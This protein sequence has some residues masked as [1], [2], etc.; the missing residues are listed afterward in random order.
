MSEPTQTKDATQAPKK[1]RG[2]AAGLG[3]SVVVGVLMIE[4]Y[5]AASLASSFF[6]ALAR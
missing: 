1:G 4:L 2:G 6:A 3:V 5:S